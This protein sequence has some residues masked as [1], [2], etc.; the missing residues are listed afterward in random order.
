MPNAADRFLETSTP[1]RISASLDAALR[2]ALNGAVEAYCIAEAEGNPIARDLIS[3]AAALFKALREMSPLP[4]VLP[5]TLLIT[6]R[7]QSPHSIHT[8]DRVPREVARGFYATRE[9]AESEATRDRTICLNDPHRIV[10]VRESNDEDVA[11]QQ[12]A[13]LADQVATVVLAGMQSLAL[14]PLTAK[15]ITESIIEQ[16]ADVVHPYFETGP[17]SLWES[18]FSQV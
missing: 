4:G 5:F 17:F 13:G 6:T 8:R 7:E 3:Q 2:S 18:S 10:V 14:H 11:L 9:E 16:V 1:P 15:R 12:L